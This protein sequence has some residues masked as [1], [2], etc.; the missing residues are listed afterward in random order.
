MTLL[1]RR[2][3]CNRK[4]EDR[5]LTDEYQE[6]KN[7][8]RA[9]DVE[10]L[11]QIIT[12][13]PDV[14]RKSNAL[15]SLVHVAA[16]EGEVGCLQLLADAGADLTLIAETG[17]SPLTCAAMFGQADAIRFLLRAGAEFDT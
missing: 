5:H 16:E 11:K 12:R 4:L 15:G 9:R 7:A 8:I 17:G 1:W 14:V 2:V 6:A 3:Q 13:F 10:L